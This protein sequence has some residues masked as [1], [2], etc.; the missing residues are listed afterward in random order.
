MDTHR[1][2]RR[3]WQPADR[4]GG[5]LDE[6][7]DDLR[8]HLPDLLIDRLVMAHAGDDDNVY[9]LGTPTRPD[10]VQ[11][12]TDPDGQPPFIIE[13]DQ[14]LTTPDPVRAAA[15]MRTWLTQLA[16]ITIA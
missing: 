14:R 13:A 11:I 15:T 9:F 6:I 7:F 2:Q 10:L 8:H 16:A 1:V 12:D 5:P 4:T 3:S